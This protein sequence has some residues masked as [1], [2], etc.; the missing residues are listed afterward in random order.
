MIAVVGSGGP[1][2]PAVDALARELGAALVRAGY[3][4]VCGGRGGVME[5]VAGGGAAVP[6][7][8]PPIVGILPGY[9]FAEA[10]P[11]LDLV[12]PSGLGHARNAVVAAAG[13]AVICVA[14]GAGALSEVALARKIGRPVLVFGG[15]GGSAALAARDLDWALPVATVPEAL[16]RLAGLLG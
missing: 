13:D 14:G 10:N 2:T 1:L 8:R 11:H 7:P 15:S 9:D 4:I 5:A 3:G 16:A 6:P 12:V